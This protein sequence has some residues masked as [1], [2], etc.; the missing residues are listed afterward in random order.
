ME[1]ELKL[2]FPNQE[3]LYA[4]SEAPW[5]LESVD[6]LSEKTSSFE[7]RYLDT[8]DRSLRD[9]RTTIRIRHVDGENYIHTVK[10]IPVA[11]PE[12][13]DPNLLSGLTSRCEWN[14]ETDR[15][16]FDIDY[17]LSQSKNAEDPYEV[18]AAT[19]VP[20]SGKELVTLSKTAFTRHVIT[21]EFE[22]ST[23]EICLDT[24]NC[25]GAGKSLPICEMEIE[26]ISGDIASV[27]KLGAL[28]S[29]NTECKPLA[30]SK[31]ARCLQLMNEE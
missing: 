28:I 9:T 8:R 30:I 23:L 21:A 6:I 31:L 20:L 14:V 12:D 13:L 24:G 29:E 16:D 2:S 5:F 10:T 11:L 19:L 22:G 15:S 27:T 7:N 3:A 1:T 4:A 26:L 25:Y 17:F 18:L